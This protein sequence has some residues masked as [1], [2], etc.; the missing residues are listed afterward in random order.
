MGTRALGVHPI[1][2]WYSQLGFPWLIV[3]NNTAEATQAVFLQ[4]GGPNG[5]IV[6]SAMTSTLITLTG[7]LSHEKNLGWLGY[8]GDEIL[9]S[10]V[11]IIINHCKDPYWPTSISWKVGLFSW[12]ICS[13]FKTDWVPFW[14]PRT[15]PRFFSGFWRLKGMNF[16][17]PTKLGS[18]KGECLILR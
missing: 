6:T 14:Q 4:E 12:L 5:Y 2:P 8:I 10:Y 17:L 7:Y 9:P 18:W 13:W 3:F 16:K 15:K 1:V 11:G